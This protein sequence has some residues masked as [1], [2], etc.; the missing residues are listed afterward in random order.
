M[1][2]SILSSLGEGLHLVVLIAASISHFVFL[3]GCFSY[4]LIT[5]SRMPLFQTNM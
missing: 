5:Y 4:L 3:T 2:V 1:G